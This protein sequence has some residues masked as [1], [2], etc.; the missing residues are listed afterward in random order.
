MFTPFFKID[1]HVCYK[2][3]HMKCISLIP[4][5]H[6]FVQDNVDNLMTRRAYIVQIVDTHLARLKM[7]WCWFSLACNIQRCH[8]LLL[9]KTYLQLLSINFPVIVITEIWFND[10]TC[11]LYSLSG[12]KFI[13][14][15]RSD[16]C[17]GGVGIFVH[18]HMNYSERN[19]LGPV[20]I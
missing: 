18:D 14:Q 7:R 2:I 9:I 3:Y 5:D 12:Y 6:D 10:V 8:E 1:S 4:A 16:K 13:E 11:D 17:G 19:D 15:H 20:S